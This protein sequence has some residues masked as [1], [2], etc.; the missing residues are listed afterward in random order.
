MFL[1]RF[2]NLKKKRK[3]QR[4]SSIV[5]LSF[6]YFSSNFVNSI[7]FDLFRLLLFGKSHFSGGKPVV[8]STCVVPF[9][10]EYHGLYHTFG[11]RFVHLWRMFGALVCFP[12]GWIAGRLWC[13]CFMTVYS[14][15]VILWVASGSPPAHMWLIRDSALGSPLVYPRVTCSAPPVHRRFASVSQLVGVFHRRFTSV[16]PAIHLWPTRSPFCALA[17]RL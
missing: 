1:F 17:F 16:L 11:A 10:F 2:T 13:T 6:Y 15:F 7:L 8:V 3:L 5:F 9:L 4:K 14:R 12:L